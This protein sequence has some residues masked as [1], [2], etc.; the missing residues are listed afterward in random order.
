MSAYPDT[1]D[2]LEA[3]LDAERVNYAS[4]LLLD[5]EDFKAEQTYHRSRL[6]RLLQALVGH[7]TLAGLLVEAPD[8][9]DPER[10]LRVL[11]GI[12]IDRHGRI[13]ELVEPHCIRLTRWFAQQAGAE[14]VASTRAQAGKSF[15]TVDLFLAAHSCPRGRSPALASGPFDALDPTVPS[16]LEERGA[17]SLMLRIEGGSDPIPGPSNHWPGGSAN[18][19][20]QRE[21]VLG[22]WPGD[23]RAM[24]DGQLAPLTEHVEGQDRSAVF[25]ARIGMPVDPPGSGASRPTLKLDAPVE[26][27]NDVRPVIYLPGKWHGQPLD[28]VTLNQP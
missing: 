9:D 25:L 16:R 5:A 4:G 28:S 10:E 7:G 24:A 8:A 17:L 1:L 15:V 6:A 18:E 20:A 19:E 11:P 12:A 2:P 23:L 13:V 27:R 26:V 14:L 22:S 3:G 21:A